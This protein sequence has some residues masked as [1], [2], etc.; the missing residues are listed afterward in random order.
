MEG[1]KI[2][3]RNGASWKRIILKSASMKM[4]LTGCE[5]KLLPKLAAFWRENIFEYFPWFSSSVAFVTTS[6]AKFHKLKLILLLKRHQLGFLRSAFNGRILIRY[7]MSK[8]IAQIRMS[9]VTTTF[10]SL[11][12]R[13]SQ[14]N[15]FFLKKKVVDQS[16][17]YTILKKNSLFVL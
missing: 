5:T 8:V 15:I 3:Q 6:F 13:C 10:V 9:K 17:D 2:H 14:R 1:L 16:I 7:R 4:Y 12:R 11:Y